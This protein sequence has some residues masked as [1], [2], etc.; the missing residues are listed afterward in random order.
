VTWPRALVVS[1]AALTACGLAACRSNT[2]AAP[3]AAPVSADTWAVVDGRTITRDAVEKAYRRSR[4]LAQPLS[5]EEALAAKLS[6]LNEMIVQD[7]LMAKAR[8]LKIDVADSELDTAYNEAKKNMTDAAFQEELQKRSLTPAD[9]RDGL[10]R[11]MITRKIMEQE[12][13]KRVAVTDRE[14]SDFFEA[15]RGRFNV[16]EEAYALAQ[17]VVT[18]VRDPQIAN[19][20]GDDATTPEAATAKTAM[21]MERLKGG[22]DFR[23]LAMNFSEDPDS[24]QRGGDL[25]LVPVSRLVKA[26]PPMRDAV[27]K[28]APNT[29]TVVSMGGAHTIVL[30]IAHEPAGQRDL[31]TPAVRDGIT[32]NLRGHKEQVLRAAF[33]TSLQNDAKVVNYLA[34][35]IVEAPARMPEFGPGAPAAK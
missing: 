21:L 11:D 27:L 20:T 7:I 23:E 25:G 2:P 13:V 28:K 17:I 5:N 24:A 31:S 1:A 4:D 15:N 30:V 19:R 34:R 33:L 35:R 6:L 10:R 26:P 22:A 16:A 29:V 14:V 32:A 8:E 9:M 3:A 12:V 18:P